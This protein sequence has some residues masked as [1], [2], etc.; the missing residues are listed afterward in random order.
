MRGGC[1]RFQAQYLRRIRLPHWR[2]IPETLRAK[3]VDAAMKRDRQACNCT[4]FM[5]FGLS[6]KEQSVFEGSAG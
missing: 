1:L 4:V 3:L 6:R 5:V 2:S